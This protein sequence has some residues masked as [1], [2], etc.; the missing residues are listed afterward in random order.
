MFL[1]ASGFS[2]TTS[3]G[4]RTLRTVAGGFHRGP[5]G[6][7]AHV[8]IYLA[9]LPSGPDAV[10]R[11][12]LHRFRTAMQSANRECTTFLARLRSRPQACRAPPRSA[13]LIT[14]PLCEATPA[15]RSPETD[16][17]RA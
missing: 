15:L 7:A 13:T 11:L 17:S 16:I 10:R 1:V 14:A 4:R 9:L 3:A 5:E 2:Q 8:R 12:K 6:P